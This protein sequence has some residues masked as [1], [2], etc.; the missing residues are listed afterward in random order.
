MGER[1]IYLDHNAT[2]PVLPEVAD[3][4]LPYLREKFGNPSSSHVYG[5]QAQLAVGRA[6]Q[7]VATLL[8]SDPA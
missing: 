1:P 7:Q 2:T 5:R 6:R 3:T 8:S 4:M